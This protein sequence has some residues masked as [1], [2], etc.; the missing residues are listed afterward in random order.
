M[1]DAAAAAASGR[2]RTGHGAGHRHPDR[3]P[4]HRRRPDR[5]ADRGHRH[6]G[7]ARARTLAS[8]TRTSTTSPA[9][10]RCWT[11]ALLRERPGDPAGPGGSTSS[12]R[13]A[14]PARAGRSDPA[15][16]RRV[17]PVNIDTHVTGVLVHATGALSTLVMSFDAVATQASTSKS[18]ATRAPWCPGSQPLRRR[19]SVASAWAGRL[20]APCRSAPGTRTPAAGFGIA[21]LAALRR[22]TS[23]GPA[24]AGF[25]RPDVMESPPHCRRREPDGG[26][27]AQCGPP[28]GGSPDGSDR[29]LRDAAQVCSTAA[30]CTGSAW[31]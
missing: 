26:G 12:V 29:D 11:W 16:G 31:T 10:A 17:V 27:A 8:R 14:T 3:A 1:L 28:G 21:D 15:P 24:A 9:A 6:D 5:H 20:G 7:H 13:R 19:C 18:M 25:P 23:H 2:L 22:G 30:C 4:G